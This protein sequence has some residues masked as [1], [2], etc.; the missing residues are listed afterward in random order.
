MDQHSSRPRLLARLTPPPSLQ[1]SRS[2][3]SNNSFCINSDSRRHHRIASKEWTVGDKAATWAAIAAGVEAA[4][5]SE[6]D[7]REEH[8]QTPCVSSAL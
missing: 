1:P 6:T 2:N 3:T 7:H 8:D 4:H 5:T